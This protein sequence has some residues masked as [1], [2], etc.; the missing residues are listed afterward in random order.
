MVNRSVVA[1]SVIAALVVAASPAVATPGAEQPADGPPAR[2]AA[3]PPD[4]LATFDGQ[5]QT[6]TAGEP[7]TV[8]GRIGTP[9]ADGVTLDSGAAAE[10]TLEVVA[11]DG[12]VLATQDVTAGPSGA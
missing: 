8:S 12:S 7:F 5:D 3:S 2:E 6:V 9:T 10:F 4:L 1:S 11:P